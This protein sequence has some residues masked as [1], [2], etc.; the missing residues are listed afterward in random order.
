MAAPSFIDSGYELFSFSG[1]LNLKCCQQPFTN[2]LFYSKIE[3]IRNEIEFFGF[4][5][6]ANSDESLTKG[7]LHGM[8][9]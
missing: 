4:Y 3:I 1:L 2:V 7:L 8:G 6:C 9:N 5:R